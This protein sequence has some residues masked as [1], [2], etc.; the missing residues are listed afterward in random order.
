[1][2]A[3]A[4][5]HVPTISEY[6][7][8][9]D[10]IEALNTTLLNFVSA[11]C[12]ACMEYYLS[13]DACKFCYA[14]SATMAVAAAASALTIT[15]SPCTSAEMAVISTDPC[16]TTA[17][18]LGDCPVSVSSVRE[19]CLSCARKAFMDRAGDCTTLCDKA[20]EDDPDKVSYAL[21]NAC[22]QAQHLASATYCLTVSSTETSS[23]FGGPIISPLLMVVTIVFGLSL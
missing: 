9:G 2:Q 18:S 17:S 7:I 23:S 3:I 4:N 6:P 15:N 21:C 19:T 8:P 13:S 14:Q 10:C 12:Q 16:W 1:L 20:A 5:Y 11:N 22:S